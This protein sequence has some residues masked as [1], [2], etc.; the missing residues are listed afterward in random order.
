MMLAA[1]LLAAAPALADQKAEISQDITVKSKAVGPALV[2]PPPAA[3]RP[4]IDE[5]LDSLELGKGD[6]GPGPETVRVEADTT[7]V[8][9]LFPLPPFLA[10][11]PARVAARYDDWLF[12]VLDGDHA[13]WQVSG[14]GP[15]RDDLS[16]DGRATD[17]RLA[18]AAGRSYRYRFT[19][20]RGS[21]AFVVECDPIELKSF[22]R[23]E[24]QGETRLEAGGPQLFVEGKAKLADTAD[25]YLDEMATRLLASDQRE[26][27]TVRAELYVA[28]PGKLSRARA[29]ALTAALAQRT[30][31]DASDIQLLVLPVDRGGESFAVFL[32]VS[33][34]PALRNE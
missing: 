32:P 19:G 30:R 27:G 14:V 20:R 23:V 7:R 2:V 33:R 18:A 6:A 28:K 15:A 13:V 25:R 34:G 3:A 1:L 12:E 11:T 29:N 8:A 17:G 22:A 31:K 4:V 24:Y 10:F 21:K 9:G 26:D 5:V 16:W